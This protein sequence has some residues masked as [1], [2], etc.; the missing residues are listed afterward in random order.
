M[1]FDEVD[2]PLRTLMRPAANGWSSLLLP[3]FGSAA[4]D[5]IREN[6]KIHQLVWF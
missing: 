5:A 1:A 3:L 2:G 6:K 4:N